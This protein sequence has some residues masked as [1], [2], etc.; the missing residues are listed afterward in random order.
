MIYPICPQCGCNTVVLFT[1]PKEPPE[2]ALL[3]YSEYIDWDRAHLYCSNGE[4]N[5]KFQVRLKDLTTPRKEKK[6]KLTF[7]TLLGNKYRAGITG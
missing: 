1:P 7:W 6:Q 4:S 3:G 5:C 2:F